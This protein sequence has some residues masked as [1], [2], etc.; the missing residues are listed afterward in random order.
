ME[1]PILAA[2]TVLDLITDNGTATFKGHSNHP[3]IAEWIKETE[4]TLAEN[5]DFPEIMWIDRKSIESNIRFRLRLA[6]TK[7]LHEAEAVR[8]VDRD[9]LLLKDV[10]FN[11]RTPVVCTMAVED[12]PLALE[13]VPA[14]IKTKQMCIDAALKNGEAA[15]FI[16]KTFFDQE[17][18]DLIVGVDRAAF[19][20]IPTRF[21][22]FAMSVKV[23]SRADFMLKCVPDLIRPAV[24]K[25]VADQEIKAAQKV[26]ESHGVAACR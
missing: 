23:V 21:K 8:T 5:F 13:H 19:R 22:T 12:N 18:C 11:L 2:S 3:G 7:S 15:R 24:Q 1:N 4:A 16:P 14:E 20:H 17:T 9:G 26:L 10:P 6:E 25:A